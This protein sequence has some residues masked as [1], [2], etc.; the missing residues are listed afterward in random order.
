MFEGTVVIYCEISGD[1]IGLGYQMGDTKFKSL[2]RQEIFPFCYT[3]RMY[4]G[5]TQS[6]IQLVLGFVPEYKTIWALR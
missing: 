1:V 6:P 3:S 2:K 5:T 4:M